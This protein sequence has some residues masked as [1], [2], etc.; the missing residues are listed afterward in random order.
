M[1]SD[2]INATSMFH[3]LDIISSGL[4]AEMA[5]SEIVAANLAN[6]G[7]T[8]TAEDPPY[9]RRSL[10]FGEMLEQ[11]TGFADADELAMGV[12]VAAINTDTET[13]PRQF[14]DP[15]HE[16]A[17][18]DGWVLGSNVDMFK[19]LVDMSV[20][21]RSYQADLAAMRTYRQMINSTIQEMR[22]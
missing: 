7:D 21:E 17:D 5:R 19:E 1:K 14:F 2:Q 12:R 20:I 9:M 6:A 3:G 15:G 8:G 10:T 22:R 13:P 16:H 4:R 11:N 18:E